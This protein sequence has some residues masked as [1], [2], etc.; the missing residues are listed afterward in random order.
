MAAA[1]KFDFGTTPFSVILLRRG[2]EK[3]NRKVEG[4]GEGQRRA[5]VHTGLVVHGRSLARIRVW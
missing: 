4:K 1:I 3:K 5:E 2:I